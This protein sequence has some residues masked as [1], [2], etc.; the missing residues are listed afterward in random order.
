MTLRPMNEVTNAYSGQDRV[1]RCGCKGRY[2]TDSKN[3]KRLYNKVLKGIAE[4]G[5]VRDEGDYV[6]YSY[7]NDRAVTLYWN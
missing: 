4:G 5:D 2:Y 7:G 6:N 3:V 1:C